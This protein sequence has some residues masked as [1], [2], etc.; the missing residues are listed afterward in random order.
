MLVYFSLVLLFEPF[1]I[2]FRQLLRHTLLVQLVSKAFV[3]CS[4]GKEYETSQILKFSMHYFCMLFHNY[5]S[6]LHEII[7]L[8][9]TK[10]SSTLVLTLGTFQRH[11]QEP[12]QT[13]KK[14]HFAKIVN[15]FSKTVHLKSLSTHPTKWSNTLKQFVGCCWRIVWLGLTILWGWC[16]KG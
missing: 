12:W 7:K 10:I 2:C 9:I 16:W 5:F 1:L 6:I 14:E 11:I 13:Y 4:C 15:Y 8:E 3:F